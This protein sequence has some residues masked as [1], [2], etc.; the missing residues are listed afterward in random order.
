MLHLVRSVERTSRSDI[1]WLELLMKNLEISNFENYVIELKKKNEKRNHTFSV[2]A[3]RLLTSLININ[4]P[5]PAD[6][7]DGERN[8]W[9]D[10]HGRCHV[11]FGA[12]WVVVIDI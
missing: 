9:R 11:V 1:T 3:D 5:P 10:G 6:R 7:N 4:P 12:R 2:P 8:G